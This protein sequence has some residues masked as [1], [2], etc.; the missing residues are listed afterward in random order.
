[1]ISL[2]SLE[3]KEI[4]APVSARRYISPRLVTTG[5]AAVCTLIRL[6][7]EDDVY[8]SNDKEIN[9]LSIPIKWPEDQNKP[10]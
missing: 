7:P 1:M 8:L 5:T 10:I 3:N 9:S 2:P 4:M 6:S